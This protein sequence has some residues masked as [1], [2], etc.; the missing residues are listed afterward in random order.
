MS[1][2]S[3]LNDEERRGRVCFSLVDIQRKFPQKHSHVLASELSR[4]KN[5][6]ILAN[7][8]SGFYVKI[9]VQYSLRGIVPPYYYIDQLMRHLG[10]P[11][12]I[13]LLSAAQLFG[14]AHQVPQG[15][16]VFTTRPAMSLST[17]KNPDVFWGYRKTIPLELLIQRNSETAAVNYSCPELTAIDLVQYSQYIGGLSRAATVLAELTAVTDF[18]KAAPSL[19]QIASLAAFQRL[20]YILDE[21]LEEKQQAEALF[22]RLTDNKSSFRWIDLSRQSKHR[23]TIAQ[24]ERWKIRVNAILEVDDL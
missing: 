4:L 18:M 8:H 19:Y 3:W 20:G 15:V 2:L 23:Q 24:N 14:A 13:S 5:H 21:V 6:K 16:C 1:I 10:R 9:P 11:Y 12:Y 7:V 17:T 22:Q